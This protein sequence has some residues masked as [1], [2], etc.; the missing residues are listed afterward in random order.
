MLNTRLFLMVALAA[1]G[2]WAPADRLWAASVHGHGLSMNC[3]RCHTPGDWWPLRADRD[4][5]HEETGFELVG[6]HAT[7][8][9][10]GCHADPVFAAVGVVCADCHADAVHRGELGV[11]C[12]RCHTPMGWRL[13]AER[14][15]EHQLTQFPLLGRHALVDCAA[16]HTT[17]Q[18]GEYGLLPS[19]CLACHHADYQAA[20]MPEHLAAGF[21]TDCELCHDADHYQWS[22]ARFD[23]ALVSGLTDCHV[24]HSGDYEDT[25]SPDHVAAGFPTDCMLCHTPTGFGG[26]A[27]D[28]NTATAFPLIG[29][30]LQ[31]GCTDCHGDGVY[32]GQPGDCYDCHADTYEG[33][34]EPNHVEEQ[35]APDHCQYCHSPADGW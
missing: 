18:A 13:A 26:A 21:P 27:F 14:L 8:T 35:F 9:C 6:E 12:E 25:Q 17:P 7:V 16:C 5:S 2:L 24:C 10:V 3:T 30:H 32:Q 28:H 11:D 19:E 31:V 34:R 20:Q 23:H 15:G 1:I 22:Q 33:T 29:L 4:F